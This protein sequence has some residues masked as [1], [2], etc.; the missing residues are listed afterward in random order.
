MLW[1][2]EIVIHCQSVSQYFIDM[3]IKGVEDWRVMGLYGDPRWEHKDQTWDVLRSLHG[4]SALPWLVL[5]D[6]NVILYFC[7]TMRKKGDGQDHRLTCKHS[8]MLLWI[9]A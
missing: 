4:N 7:T 5:G 1:R 3:V 6:F 8:M 2:K 9:V